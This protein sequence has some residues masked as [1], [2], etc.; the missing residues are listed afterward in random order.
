MKPA[1]SFALASV[2]DAQAPDAVLYF[3]R[4][5]RS[6]VVELTGRL[7]SH[8]SNWTRMRDREQLA[9]VIGLLQVCPA[10][11]VGMNISGASV[12]A[13]DL[14]RDVLADLEAD[15]SLANRL[16]LEID[17]SEPLELGLGAVFVKRIQWLGCQVALDHFGCRY[18]VDVG[19][20][21]LAPDIIKI[22]GALV[23]AATGDVSAL[24]RLKRLVRLASDCARHVVV[25]GVKTAEDARLALDVGATWVQANT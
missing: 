2:H 3:E 5:G 9:R 12:T 24:M 16:I 23:Q 10:L 14:W 11:H 8:G 18:G 15:Q 25:L 6:R 17:E 4:L 1:S 7:E 21:I 20:A 22:D 13:P 19:A